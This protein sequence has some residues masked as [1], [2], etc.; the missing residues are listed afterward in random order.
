MNDQIGSTLS[1][2][3]R[4]RGP[5]VAPVDDSAGP[6]F[7]SEAELVKCWV[8][9]VADDSADPHFRRAAESV[10]GEGRRY[11]CNAG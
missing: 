7:T 2:R 5:N 8:V 1:M 6:G 9:D 11:P 10:E 4:V 3:S